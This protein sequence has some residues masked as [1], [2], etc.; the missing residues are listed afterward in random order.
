[1]TRASDTIK[2]LIGYTDNVYLNDAEERTILNL[3]RT[4]INFS[5]TIIDLD[6]GGYLDNL[7]DRIDPDDLRELV[8]VL[9]GKLPNA[10]ADSKLSR[11]IRKREAMY[12]TSGG[13]VPLNGLWQSLYH[14]SRNLQ[15]N[16]KAHNLVSMRRPSRPRPIPAGSAR[17]H[18]R[19]SADPAPPGSTRLQ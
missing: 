3:L 11:E 14:I 5:Q 1:M 12:L 4:D 16:I 18:R 6:K 19:R 2:K 17:N 13:G 9:G 15:G 7:F 8:E 10:T